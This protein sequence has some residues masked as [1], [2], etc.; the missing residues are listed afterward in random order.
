MWTG[1]KESWS[2][3]VM[4][5]GSCQSLKARCIGFDLLLARERSVHRV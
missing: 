5:W 1:R 4:L 2:W 3:W